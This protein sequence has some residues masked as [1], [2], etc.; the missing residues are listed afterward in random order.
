MKLGS[1]IIAAAL[2][3][4]VLSVLVGLGVQRKIIRKQGIELTRNTMRAAVIEAETV[5][6]STSTLAKN[7]AFQTEKLL[8]KLK[9]SD[10]LRKSTIYR[11]IP[12]VA[13]W[14]AIREVANRE[15]YEFRVPKNGARNAK[16]LPTKDEEV[17]LATLEKGGVEEIFQVDEA[18]NEILYARPIILSTDCLACHGDPKNSPTGDGKDM[19]GFRMENWKAGDVHGAFVLKAKLDRVDAVVRAGMG[20]TLIWMLPMTGLI[21]I[22]FYFL[23]QKLIVRP[24]G[25]SIAQIDEASKQTTAAS[26][27]INSASQHLAEGA[28]TQASSLE[29]TSAS[30]EELSS[31]T[32][33]T[34]ENANQAK[35]LANETRTKAEDGADQMREMT[36]AMDA[37]RASGENVA[38]ILKTIDEIAFQTNI[39]ALNAAVEAARAGESGLG[40]AVVAEEVRGL[41]QRSAQAARETADKITDSL[42][43]TARGVE[44]SSQVADSL[45]DILQRSRKMNELIGD[46]ATA[47]EEQSTGIQQINAA[48][49]NMDRVTQANAAGAE[50]TASSSTELAAQAQMLES[51]VTELHQL[52]G[53]S[54]STAASSI[55]SLTARSA[56]Q[57]KPTDPSHPAH[58]FTQS[59]HPS[60]LPAAKPHSNGVSSF[61]ASKEKHVSRF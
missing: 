14:E 17:I 4:V 25:Q 5:R 21:A 48:V 12:V 41:A 46:I 23:N 52:I 11:T 50:Q 33:R 10:D 44:I 51:A 31:M 9:S 40:F 24:L 37:I 2:G 22:G 58:E 3:A 16:N 56:S 49:A 54:R 26:A 61:S 18:R 19:L 6:E 27:E 15:G 38:K 13:A 34:A 8:Q 60:A 39:L 55:P 43:K 47:S 30:L 20:E 53:D 1:K 7:D 32:R 28:T 57:S 29:E 42:N 45:Q 59:R 36:V 35:D